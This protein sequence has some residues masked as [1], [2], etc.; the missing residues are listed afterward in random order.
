MSGEDDTT[1]V[2]K[3]LDEYMKRKQLKPS[4]DIANNLDLEMKN[5]LMGLAIVMY[6]GEQCNPVLLSS[7]RLTLIIYSRCGNG[8]WVKFSL[9]QHLMATLV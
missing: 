8:E 5:D 3:M 2:S 4:L 7:M 9:L 6:S 1:L